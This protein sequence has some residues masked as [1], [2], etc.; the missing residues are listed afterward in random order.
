MQAAILPLSWPFRTKTI[1]VGQLLL[2]VK[3][4]RHGEVASQR[5]AI[6]ALI[7]EERQKL[8]VLGSDIL[9]YGLSPIDRSAR[10]TT[11]I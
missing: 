1:P 5:E 6:D 4:P 10:A 8:V 2:D 3:N 7:A 11:Y 9:K